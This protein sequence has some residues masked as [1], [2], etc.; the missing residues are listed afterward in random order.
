[1]S[2]AP[3]KSKAKADPKVDAKAE[4]SAAAPKRSKLN[5][6]NWPT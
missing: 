4:K 5:F 6:Q 2:T 3:D 1:M